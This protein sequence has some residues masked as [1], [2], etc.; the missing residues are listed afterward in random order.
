MTYNIFRNAS[1]QHVGK[2]GATMSS[3]RD[4]IGI[5][6][7]GK[8]DYPLLFAYVIKYVNCKIF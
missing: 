1:C 5:D 6:A 2:S 3:H 7:V 4:Q 8:I